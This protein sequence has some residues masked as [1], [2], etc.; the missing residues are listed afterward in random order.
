MLKIRLLFISLIFCSAAFGQSGSFGN[1]TIFEGGDLTIHG[2]HDFQGN[3]LGNGGVLSSKR[4]GS[5]GFMNFA[6]N[7]SYKNAS[8]KA[9]LDGYVRTYR[10]DR[11]IFP[12]GDKGKFRPAGVSGASV[13]LP[14]DA[15]YYSLDPSDAVLPGTG[16]FSIESKESQIRLVTDQEYWD[17]NGSFETKITLSWEL[18]SEIED[19]T[20][21]QLSSLRIVGWDGSEWVIIPSS[22]DDL[23]IFGV[24]SVLDRG[25]IT[26]SDL[27]A[28]DSFEVYTLASIIID[29]D[30]DG[31]TDEDEARDNTNHLDPCEFLLASQT[32]TP[33]QEWKDSDC[34]GDGLTNQE[35]I[36]PDGD[37]IA[38]PD[39]TDPLNPDTDGDGNP[40]NTDPN[41][42]TAT[43]NDDFGSAVIGRSAVIDILENDDF[44]IGTGLE[45]TDTFSGTAQG[46]V[47]FDAESGTMRYTPSLD[48]LEGTEVTVIYKVCHQ[49]V[50]ASAVVTIK[51]LAEEANITP[52]NFS[53]LGYNDKNRNCVKDSGEDETDLPDSDLYIKIFDLDDNLLYTNA[54]N[55]GQFEV[56]D[57]TGNLSQI[58]YFILDTNE[59]DTDLIPNLPDGW[60]SGMVSPKLKR[61]F[62]FDGIL[63][64]NTSPVADLLD[65]SWKSTFPLTICFSRN[66]FEAISDNFENLPNTIHESLVAGNVLTND[67]MNG[68]PVQASDVLI[69]ISDDGGLKGI[70]IDENGNLKLPKNSASGS[71]VV[72]YSICDRSNPTN[73]SE[74]MILIKLSQ[75]VN[76]KISKVAQTQSV[77]EGD[78]MG[79]VIRIENNS[80][81]R[82][83]NVQVKDLLPLG[84]SYI[85]SSVSA[86]SPVVAIKDQEITWTFSSLSA[87]ESIEITLKVKVALLTDG[88]EKTILN[89]ATVK[90]DE[91]ESSM[92]DNSSTAMIKVSPS[93]NLKINKV[94]QAESVYE[95]DEMEYVIRVENTSVGRSTNVQVK[96]LLPL[97]LSYISSSASAG[98]PIITTKGQEI[99]W[100]FSSLSAGESVEI[101]L[102]VKVA[103]LT[104]E[105]EKTILNQATVKGDEEESSMADNTSTAM[106]KVSPFFIPNVITP[107]GDGLNDTF[108]IKG[109]NKFLK[110]EILIFNRYG[111]H[112]YKKG[113]YKNDWSAIGLVDGTYFYVLNV[114]DG[115]GKKLDFQGWIQVITKY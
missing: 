8:D 72:V 56:V 62:H 17:I 101:T 37:G 71:Y 111:D 84:L 31:V 87:G 85:S 25:S 45:L 82:S 35:E 114:T 4:T 59:D 30:G 115:N 105:N 73:C 103:P 108:E 66:E 19:L 6:P 27:Y 60:S 43:A 28:P 79:Y 20:A 11:F 29:T 39:G 54:I 23:S 38:G 22:V 100:T 58:Y 91:E 41:P 74:A 102:K 86:G 15:A 33:S 26:S 5:R 50:C 69:S 10:S 9:H 51:I 68:M 1:T 110:N 7:S 107:N 34:D 89:Q 97:G 70:S 32:L 2:E 47:S 81:S 48:E 75:S 36:D 78:E 99:T 112:V 3:D 49:E 52:I 64:T 94:A 24:P 104:D 53:V 67:L 65:S 80:S 83:T 63:K 113:D 61:Y 13:L 55:S 98:S 76:L 90:G 93:V 18:E 77:Y 21:G 14:L 109:L 57:F 95:G 12:I 88:K 96:D 46:I 16:P 106:I 42:T 44:L 92:L 40:D